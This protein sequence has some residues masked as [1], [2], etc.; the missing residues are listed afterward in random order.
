MFL[1]VP[2]G[3]VGFPQYER[4]WNVAQ[5]YYCKSSIK[6]PGGGGGWGLI[7]FKPMGGGGLIWEW[8]F[9]NLEKTMASVLQN[10]LEYE[11]EK[12]K[13]TSVLGSLLKP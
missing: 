1:M 8:G 9:F 4:I 3:Y 5:N 6:P 10:E 2:I 13:Y 11:V 7:H 12:L